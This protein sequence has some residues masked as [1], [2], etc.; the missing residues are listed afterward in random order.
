M[1]AFM[2][3]SVLTRQN[4]FIKKQL[5][6]VMLWKVLNS[7]FVLPDLAG[8][9]CSPLL[10]SDPDLNPKLPDQ[11]QVITD[12]HEKPPCCVLHCQ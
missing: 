8:P 2:A 11:N 6:V 5:K 1:L 3:N 9:G 10:L 4:V 7:G 12:E